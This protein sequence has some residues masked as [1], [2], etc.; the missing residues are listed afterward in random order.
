MLGLN[1]L[2]LCLNEP[3]YVKTFVGICRNVGIL[4]Q[5]LCELDIGPGMTCETIGIF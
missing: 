1:L 4:F 5:L 3:M 2:M